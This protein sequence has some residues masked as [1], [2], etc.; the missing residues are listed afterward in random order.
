MT[1]F[2]N[3]F[4]VFFLMKAVV[5]AAGRGVRMGQLTQDKPKVLIEINGKPFLYYVLKNLQKAGVNEIGI[6][7]GYKKEKV[8]AFADKYGFDD[9]FIEQP[10]LLGTGDAV[11]RVKEWVG[12]EDFIL[13]MGD[14]LYSSRDINHLASINDDFLRVAAFRSEHP[15]R[16]GVLEVDGNTLVRIE[17]K[18]AHPKSSLVNTGLYKLT[19]EIFEHLVDLKKSPRG[20][21]ELTDA[22][23]HLAALGRVKIYELMDYWID[24]SI[25]EDLPRV[26]EKIKELGL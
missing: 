5:L 24:M 26:E 15:E 2:N 13:T 23:T 16:Y 4:N 3:F 14:N 19:P 18:P 11:M 22:I 7:V 21:I 25:K 8:F 9:I 20:E 10:S 1:R 12:N 17:E 6:V